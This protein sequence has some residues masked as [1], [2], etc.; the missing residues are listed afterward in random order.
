MRDSF[1]NY[2]TNRNSTRMKVKC[3]HP[4]VRSVFCDR[5]FLVGPQFPI[6]TS[7]Q[8]NGA[9][10]RRLVYDISWLIASRK[11]TSHRLRKPVLRAA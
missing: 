5:D 3:A 11:D 7:E 2:D 10:S 9:W 6:L 8:F 4:H 1:A